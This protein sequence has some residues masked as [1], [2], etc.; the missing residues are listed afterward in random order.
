[1]SLLPLPDLAGPAGPSV[2]AGADVA[3][4]AGLAWLDGCPRPRFEDDVWSFDG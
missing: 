1:M 3:A 4:T 2:F